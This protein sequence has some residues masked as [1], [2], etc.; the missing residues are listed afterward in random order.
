MTVTDKT[1]TPA[2]DLAK[3]RL[4]L[5]CY[6]FMQSDKLALPTIPDVSFKIRRAMNDDEANN[7]KIAR[8]V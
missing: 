7:S 5:D 4:Y 1:K 3:N 6:K 8:V 2:S